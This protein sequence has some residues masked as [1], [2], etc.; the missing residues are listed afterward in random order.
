MPSG[1]ASTQITVRSS[2]PRST[3][4][5]AGCERRV[6]G[7][8]SGRTRSPVA[9]P[10]PSGSEAMYG[11]RFVCVSSSRARPTKPICD[12]GSRLNAALAMP[13][14]ARSTGREG[15]IRRSPSRWSSPTGV[16]TSNI[17]TFERSGRL[18]D[19]QRRQFSER[20]RNSALL[21]FS[22]AHDRKPGLHDRMLNDGGV[23]ASD[24]NLSTATRA[25]RLDR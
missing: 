20:R 8:T 10:A 19:E 12:S 9:R 13:S 24:P 21:L 23:H 17:G 15:R 11:M 18:V 3:E 16:T 2:A 1:A 6:V 5:H 25:A 22:V 7:A 4:Q 14:P